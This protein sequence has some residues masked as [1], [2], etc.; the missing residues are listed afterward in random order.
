MDIAAPDDPITP[1]PPLLEG[2]RWGSY[3]EFGGTSG[4]GPH[5]AGAAAIIL[6]AFPALAGTHMRQAMRVGALVDSFVGTVP[7]DAWGWG[8]LR[9]GRVLFGEDPPVNAPPTLTIEPPEE[10]R[11]GA[12]ARI[13]PH[14]RDPEGGDDALLVRWDVGYDGTWDTGWLPIGPLERVFDA[15]GRIDVKAQV[16]DEFGLPGAAAVSFVVGEAVERDEEIDGGVEAVE[17]AAEPRAEDAAEK[18]EPAADALDGE[19]GGDAGPGHAAAGGA[20]GCAVVR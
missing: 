4:A 13:V 15:P 19:S 3:M 16:R 8:K 7:N 2:M 11:A 18:I 10:A 6:Q 9:I 12:P 20:C 17:D 5:A 1:A 14:G